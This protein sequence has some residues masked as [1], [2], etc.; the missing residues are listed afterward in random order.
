MEY[1]EP[2]AVILLISKIDNWLF[3]KYIVQ[4]LKAILLFPRSKIC[5]KRP[6]FAFEIIFRFK[7]GQIIFGIL[8]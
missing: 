1:I 8:L 7:L 4:V 6:W 2:L 3:F 5:T